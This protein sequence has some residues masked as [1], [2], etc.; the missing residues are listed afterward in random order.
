[1]AL[2]NVKAQAGPQEAEALGACLVVGGAGES[3][4]AVA[5]QRNVRRGAAT[6]LC[7]HGKRL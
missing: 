5:D 4:Q 6:L 1:M 2:E 7:L 3:S